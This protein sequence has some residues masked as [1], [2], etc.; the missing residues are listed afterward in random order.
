MKNFGLFLPL[1][2]LAGMGCSSTESPDVIGHWEGSMV[3]RNTETIIGLDLVKEEVFKGWFSIPAQGLLFVPVSEFRLDNETI[4]FQVPIGMQTIRFEGTVNGGEIEGT[5]LLQGSSEAFTLKRDNAEPRRPN[6]RKEPSYSGKTR[7]I[8]LGVEAG[9]LSGTLRTPENSAADTVVLFI[10][11]S[12]PT[13]RDGNSAL[14]GGKNNS[15]KM[16]SSILAENGFASLSYDKRMI[17]KSASIDVSEEELVFDDFVSD[18]VGWIQKAKEELGFTKV[19]LFGHSEGALIAL[20]AAQKREVDGVV[21]A[22]GAGFPM[23]VTLK[24]QL[25]R[26]GGYDMERVNQIIAEL[27]AGNSVT[28]IGPQ[29]QPLFRESVQPFLISLFQY[30]PKEEIARLDVPIL[31]IQGGKDIQTTPK[32]AQRLQE[33]N[34]DAKLV[35][36]DSMNHVLKDVTDTYDNLASYADP[37]VPL[38]EEFQQEVLSFCKGG[39]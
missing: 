14:M 11:G 34:P 31:I 21:A 1:I 30:D 22:A 7:E 23:Y 27:R 8:S 18:A 10:A 15:L 9:A 29:L 38:S 12:G 5:Y 32:D 20:R 33:G 26:Q 25:E 2:A 16:V 35:V 19:I 4:K 13:D 3:V 28:D 17:G 36:I 39:E 24:E 6:E 37:T